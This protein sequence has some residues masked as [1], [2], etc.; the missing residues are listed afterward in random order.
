MNLSIKA[1]TPLF[2]ISCSILIFTL[3]CACK[4]P[5]TQIAKPAELRLQD[6]VPAYTLR[7]DLAT[8]DT[9]FKMPIDL[10]E[11]SGLSMNTDGNTLLA[12]QDEKAI[13]YTIDIKNGEILAET[14]FWKDG[15]YEGI[16]KVGEK[17]YVVKS[18]G[19][20][21]EIS[22]TEDGDVVMEKYKSALRKANDV[23]G[24]GYDLSTNSLLLSC[25]GSSSLGESTEE[26]SKAVYAFSLDSMRLN[27][28]P[29]FLIH[30]ADVQTYLEMSPMIQNVEKLTE[31][32]QPGETGFTF[33]P[34]AVAIHPKTKEIYLLSATK[35]LL[36]VLSTEGRIAHI[37]KL[38]KKIHP[39]AE[40]ICFAADGTLFIANEGKKNKK[41]KIHR[42][43]MK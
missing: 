26:L 15:D 11:I 37:E 16:E 5:A 23:E 14:S 19:T 29:K 36:V 8:P 33:N 30:L 20:I 31:Y 18:T 38:S 4:E 39:Q 3:F 28:T 34:S 42:F 40:G 12:V 1:F 9:T 13:I 25:K 2:S 27:E 35:K 43:L 32:F 22:Q 7:Y 41:G 17:I 6:T 24:L 21:Y 10:I